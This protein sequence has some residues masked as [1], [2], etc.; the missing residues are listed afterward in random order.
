MP[1]VRETLKKKKKQ[2]STGAYWAENGQRWTTGVTPV[3]PNRAMDSLPVLGN[4]V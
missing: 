1:R 4:Q 3:P 2:S